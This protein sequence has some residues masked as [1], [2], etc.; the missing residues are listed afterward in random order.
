M[1]RPNKQDGTPGADSRDE[2]RTRSFGDGPLLRD[3][4]AERCRQEN[5]ALARTTRLL[6]AENGS[7]EAQLRDVQTQNAALEALVCEQEDYLAEVRQL[8][9]RLEERRREWR[10][11]YAE[12]TGHALDDPVGASARPG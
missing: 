10:R 7:L 11:R 12:L 5:A 9:T 4:A 8:V 3:S 6:G 1:K 2:T